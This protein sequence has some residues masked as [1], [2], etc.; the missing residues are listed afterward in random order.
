MYVHLVHAVP[1]EARESVGS[2]VVVSC[3]VECWEPNPN[4]HLN[5]LQEE[6]VLL[7]SQS[8]LQ[9]PNTD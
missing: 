4:P 2:W 6:Q 8:S 1:V 3:H 7:T 9:P 5:P